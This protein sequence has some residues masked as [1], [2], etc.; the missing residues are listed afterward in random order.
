M[1]RLAVIGAAA[2]R[3]GVVWSGVAV[4][5]LAVMVGSALLLTGSHG[6]APASAP[7]V[8]VK[9]HVMPT[10]SVGTG[11]PVAPAAQVQAAQL[12]AAGQ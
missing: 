12:E 6:H 7:D 11:R 4:A 9:R 5:V 10:P 1:P 8:A 3:Y 2:V